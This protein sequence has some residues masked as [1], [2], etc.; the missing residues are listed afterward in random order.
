[1]RRDIYAKDNGREKLDPRESKM[2]NLKGVLSSLRKRL[3]KKE[4]Q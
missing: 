2:R 1:M 3:S 4:G